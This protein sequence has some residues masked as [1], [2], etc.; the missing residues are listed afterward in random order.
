MIWYLLVL[1]PQCVLSSCLVFSVAPF[2][3]P[4]FFCLTVTE[5]CLF[6]VIFLFILL[7]LLMCFS[8]W[9]YL[10]VSCAFALEESILFFGLFAFDCNKTFFLFLLF[11]LFAPES[12]IRVLFATSV[13][14]LEMLPLFYLFLRQLA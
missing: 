13:T 7:V 1:P 14:Q 4:D 2:T 10:S 9:T 11:I 3:L 6:C 5:F 8:S 12:W